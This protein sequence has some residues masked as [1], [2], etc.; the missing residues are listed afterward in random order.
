[1][2]AATATSFVVLEINNFQLEEFDL[3]HKTRDEAFFGGGGGGGCAPSCSSAAAD[4][5]T[6]GKVLVVFL[7]GLEEEDEE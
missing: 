2:L 6:V 1:M 4:P 7:H 5:T 3:L